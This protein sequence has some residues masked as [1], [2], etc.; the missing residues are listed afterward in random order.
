MA[1]L[2]ST[3][4]QHYTIIDNIGITRNPLKK[5]AHRKIVEKVGRL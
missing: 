4:Q 5:K 3:T 1:Y 2:Y